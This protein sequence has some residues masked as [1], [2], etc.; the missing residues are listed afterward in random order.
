MLNRIL[1]K[2]AYYIV[3]QRFWKNRTLQT[4]DVQAC[5]AFHPQ[6]TTTEG[7]NEK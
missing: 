4:G 1:T 2:V 3:S 7:V 6:M 5:R